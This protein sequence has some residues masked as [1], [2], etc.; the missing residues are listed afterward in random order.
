MKNNTILK[1]K[2]RCDFCGVETDINHFP[3]EFTVLCEHCATHSG[4][5]GGRAAV[6]HIAQK[7]T[8]GAK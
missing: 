6:E 1:P 4:I 8:G 3:D 2:L 7:A 5:L